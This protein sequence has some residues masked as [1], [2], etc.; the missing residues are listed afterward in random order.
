MNEITIISGKGGTGKTTLTASL[1]QLMDAVVADCDVDAPN[2][3]FILD[4]KDNKQ[5]EYSGAS[6]AEITGKCIECNKCKE[7]CR[8]NAIN[9]DLE[10][11][12]TKC[13]GCGTC[14]YICPTD[15]I[16]LKKRETGKII[17]SE[18]RFGEMV[19]A[20]LNIG[21]EA[22]GKLVSKVKEEARKITEESEKETL[23]IDGSPGTGC[24]VIASIGGSDLALIITEPTASGKHDLIRILKVVEHF[25]IEPIICIN[26][27]DL[28]ENKTKE[29]LDYCQKNDYEVISKLPYDNTAIEAISETKTIIEKNNSELAKKIK[30]LRNKIQKK[31]NQKQKNSNL[32]N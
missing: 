9:K 13:E 26:K 11:I 29:I 27:F 20:D 21:E 18:T 1:A 15:A 2:L 3:K 6:L 28:N 8:F 10:V 23:L 5:E 31:L 4:P 14:E 32:T 30:D 19:Y 7:A 17:T 25:E 16:T 22:S 24:P 12:K